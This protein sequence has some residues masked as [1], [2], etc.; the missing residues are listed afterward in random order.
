MSVMHRPFCPAFISR[1]YQHVFYFVQINMDG[2]IA[3]VSIIASLYNNRVAV[4]LSSRSG[5]GLEAKFYGLGFDLA[6]WTYGLE[7]PGLAWLTPTP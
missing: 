1:C 5:L 2:W 6:L 3:S 4:M 7:G